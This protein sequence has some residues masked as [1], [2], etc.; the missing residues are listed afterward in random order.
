M[1][2]P[3]RRA[4]DLGP[5]VRRQG[6]PSA[7]CICSARRQCSGRGRLRPAPFLATPDTGDA[8]GAKVI[9]DRDAGKPETGKYRMSGLPPTL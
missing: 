1:Q 3:V 9:V 5:A 8:T 4:A 7:S 6:A 2:G